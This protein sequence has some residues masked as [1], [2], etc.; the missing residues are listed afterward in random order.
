MQ[1]PEGRDNILWLNG[2]VNYL[3]GVMKP[4][5]DLTHNDAVWCWDDVQEKAWNDIKSPIVSAPVLAYY[6]STEV[7]EIQCYSSQRGL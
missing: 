7:L 5:R 2:M 4:L 3:S 1:C 6:K